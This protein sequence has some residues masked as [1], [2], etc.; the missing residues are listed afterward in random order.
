MHAK[1]KSDLMSTPIGCEVVHSD[2]PCNQFKFCSTVS[3]LKMCNHDLMG[4]LL[5]IVTF[6]DGSQGFILRQSLNLSKNKK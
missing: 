5:A 1:I 2:P 6:E 4:H 3:P